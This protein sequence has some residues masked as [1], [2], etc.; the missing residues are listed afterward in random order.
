MLY[1]L[2]QHILTIAPKSHANMSKSCANFISTWTTLKRGTMQVN[3]ITTSM[4]Q[5]YW[6]LIFVIYSFSPPKFYSL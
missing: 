1:N 6:R 3:L 4:S 5:R 2:T